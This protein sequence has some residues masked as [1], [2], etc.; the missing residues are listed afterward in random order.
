MI[1]EFRFPNITGSTT[2]EQMA[3]FRSYMHQLVEQLNWAMNSIDQVQT[4]VVTN[5]NKT[6]EKS[7]NKEDPD[8]EVTFDA[9]KPLIIK[10]AEIVSAYYEEMNTR[11]VG[12]YVAQSDFGTFTEVTEQ[13]ISQNSTGI[14][15]T[16]TNI[17]SIETDIENLNF[18]LAEA[19]AHIR[20]GLLYYDENEVPVYGLEI[21]QKNTVDGVEVFNKYARFTSDRLS[22][23]DKNDNEVAYVSDYKLF[24]RNVEITSTYKIGGYKD[25]VMASG[26][27][28]TKW[29]GWDGGN[30]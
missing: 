6:I 21:G 29:V 1:C 9:L 11:F 28:V 3:Q 26:D 16:F 18:N 17:Q 8:I 15:Q 25:E 22:F 7:A 19:I 2:Q 4:Q 14:E 20:S 30:G 10:S 5:I 13:K 27:V 23:Y 24:I 12:E